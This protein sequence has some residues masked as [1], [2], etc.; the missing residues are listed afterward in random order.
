MKISDCDEL[1]SNNLSY[2]F[3]KHGKNIKEL[4]IFN[5]SLDDAPTFIDILSKMPNLKR[6][7]LCNV[8]KMETYIDP[9][10]ILDIPFSK[11]ETL[12]IINCDSHIIKCFQTSRLTTFKFSESMSLDQPELLLDF[13]SLQKSL[14][15]LA[16]HNIKEKHSQLFKAP[17]D[18]E[19]IPFRLRKLSLT[20]FKLQESPNDYNHLLKFLQIHA[21][22]IHELEIGHVFPDFIFEYIFSK[23][24]KLHVLIIAE[25]GF[26]NN[27]NLFN[28][29][30]SNA[31]IT[32]LIIR[33]KA[34]I[35]EKY[36]TVLL[37]LLPNLETLISDS[38]QFI[39]MMNGK[40]NFPLV[41]NVKLCGLLNAAKLVKIFPN[42]EKVHLVYLSN[43]D[44]SVYCGA[45]SKIKELSFKE[46]LYFGSAN[47]DFIGNDEL[48]VLRFGKNMILN[49]EFFNRIRQNCRNLKTVKVLKSSLDNVGYSEVADIS[50]LRFYEDIESEF[51]GNHGKFWDEAMIEE[52]K[53]ETPSRY[54]EDDGNDVLQF[55]MVL[56]E[57][58]F[59]E[60]NQTDEDTDDSDSTSDDGS[61]PVA[62]TFSGL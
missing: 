56:Q 51:V 44:I 5:S 27:V 2:I 29:L 45:N 21:K 23:F 8:S 22:T 4:R 58:S 53:P 13:L 7:V 1:E 31:S 32:K 43:N 55:N 33:F 39:D 25:E 18:D 17:V 46:A 26:T 15:V 28:R 59:E 6:C 9:E 40:Q 57:L 42:V 41:R 35:P 14:K 24:T 54:L 11:L 60:S 52:M 36:F 38:C 16:L 61:F 37:N 20:S 34:R 3:T 47:G 48:Q 30:E 19:D 12:E 49:Q 50:S 10:L 62:G